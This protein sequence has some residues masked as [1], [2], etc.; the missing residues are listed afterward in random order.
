MVRMGLTS[1]EAEAGGA[2]PQGLMR[3]CARGRGRFRPRSCTAMRLGWA[4]AVFGMCTSSTPALYVAVI[5]SASGS[6]QREAPAEVPNA[7]SL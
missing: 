5:C 6:A 1:C 2:H 3:A 7:R 4:A